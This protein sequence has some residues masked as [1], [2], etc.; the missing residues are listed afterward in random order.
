M[1]TGG[2]GVKD[3]DANRFPGDFQVLIHL[4]GLRIEDLGNHQGDGSGH[5]GRRD[6]M[7]AGR[8][9]LYVVTSADDAHVDPEDGAGH[10]RHADGHEA[11]DL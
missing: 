9:R 1:G 6:Q 5:Q 3:V 2:Y 4:F 10:G 11:E 7:L 8:H